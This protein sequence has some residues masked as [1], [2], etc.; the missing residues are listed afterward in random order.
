MFDGV[1]AKCSRDSPR[2]TFRPMRLLCRASLPHG[3][4]CAQVAKIWTVCIPQIIKTLPALCR[5]DVSDET[6][7]M[8]SKRCALKLQGGSA[9]PRIL[10]VG[11][12]STQD[13][14][15]ACSSGLEFVRAHRRPRH[16][17]RR[18]PLHQPTYARS[19]GVSALRALPRPR[20]LATA[21]TQT[22]ASR[23]LGCRCL[24]A[25][26]AASHSFRFA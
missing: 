3:R 1:F 5:H 12:G 24:R 26:S 15:G 2:S 21:Q 17:L 9:P 10:T 7:V 18:Q 25:M 19:D 23:S 11:D 14:T 22:L 6:V 20:H 4:G 16:M 8:L 13:V